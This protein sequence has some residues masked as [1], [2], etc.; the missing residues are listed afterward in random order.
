MPNWM[1]PF[2]ADEVVFLYV[3][4]PEEST[5][6]WPIF[7]MGSVEAQGTSD[8][9]ATDL[10]IPGAGAAEAE[11]LKGTPGSKDENP[12]ADCPEE[13]D[14]I[15][16]APSPSAAS[17]AFNRALP[18]L[19]IESSPRLFTELEFCGP[20]S[21]PSWG[22]SQIRRASACTTSGPHHS[23]AMGKNSHLA[24]RSATLTALHRSDFLLSQRSRLKPA[25]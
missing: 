19:G 13:D 14:A 22:P 17:L 8:A 21:R 2:K 5:P 23:P 24:T 16:A 15:L 18:L 9:D 3:V 25:A 4:S 7:L 11:L 6:R 1:A 20:P 10:L 12:T